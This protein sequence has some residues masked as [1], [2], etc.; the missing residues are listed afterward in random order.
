[1]CDL[2]ALNPV[3]NMVFA[4]ELEQEQTDILTYNRNSRL[5]QTVVEKYL[6]SDKKEETNDMPSL[7]VH[8]TDAKYG[9]DYAD[10][11]F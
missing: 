8:E 1:M 6:T 5:D 9:D 11:P 4:A 3:G 10:I 7:S 2:W